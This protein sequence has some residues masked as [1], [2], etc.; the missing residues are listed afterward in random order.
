MTRNLKINFGAIRD[1]AQEL[2]DYKRALEDMAYAI[3]SIE[4]NLK[5]SEGSAVE[6]LSRGAFGLIKQINEQKQEI[7][8]L[9]SI[10]DDYYCQMT[11]IITP[12]N[13]YEYSEVGRN[14]RQRFKMTLP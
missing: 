4:N 9:F 10:F 7:E 8:D 11:D 1:T 2:Y 14:C 5:K 13:I 6:A 3:M 12:H